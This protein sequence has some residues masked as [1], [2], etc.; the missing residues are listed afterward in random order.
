M[1]AMLLTFVILILN[2]EL[3]CQDSTTII[4]GN[5]T[6]RFENFDPKDRVVYGKGCGNIGEDPK[7][8]ILT[9]QL[10]SSRD[11]IIFT[12][13]LNDDILE[14]QAYAVEGLCRI[15]NSGLNLSTYQKIRIEK[16]KESKKEIWSCIG[17]SYWKQKLSTALM[18]FEIK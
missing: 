15:H 4:L 8:R 12:E 6:I 3:M 18:K 17:C 5:D 11:T 14:K 13:W 1:R 9:E 16:I 2:T 10:I 7:M